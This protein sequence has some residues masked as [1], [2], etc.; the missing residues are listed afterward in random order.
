MLLQCINASMH[1]RI[2][3][4]ARVCTVYSAVG[5]GSMVKAVIPTT[6]MPTA[7]QND[8]P[9]M[10]SVGPSTLDQVKVAKTNVVS[11]SKS[12]GTLLWDCSRP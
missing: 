8:V 5:S 10:K 3:S 1:M 9:G 7:G 4:K 6:P 2:V 11:L 12:N